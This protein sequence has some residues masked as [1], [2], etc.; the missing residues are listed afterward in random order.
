[1]PLHGKG[2]RE[3]IL[4]KSIVTNDRLS[5]ISN[6]TLERCNLHPEMRTAFG[7]SA[8]LQLGSQIEKA[9]SDTLASKPNWNETRLAHPDRFTVEEACALA[10]RASDEALAL[11]QARGALK[12]WGIDDNEGRQNLEGLKECLAA[13][14]DHLQRHSKSFLLDVLANSNA[15]LLA[16]F[17]KARWRSN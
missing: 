3:R 9:H 16:S 12:L 14:G 11:A 5:G 17:L 7:F 1:M 15:D 6:E 10:K 13:C 8:L 4:G 2:L